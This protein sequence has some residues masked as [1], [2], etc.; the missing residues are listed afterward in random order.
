M[1]QFHSSYHKNLVSRSMVTR[2]YSFLLAPLAIEMES[3]RL[4]WQTLQEQKKRELEEMNRV[5]AELGIETPANSV[6]KKPDHPG[7]T[8]DCI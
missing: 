3:Q 4:V 6:D 1:K 2:K 8:Q 5:L 7:E